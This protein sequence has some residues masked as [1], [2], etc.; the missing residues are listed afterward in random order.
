VSSVVT[1][2][3]LLAWPRPYFEPGG[4]D[5]HLFYK[6]HGD[7]SKPPPVSRAKYRTAGIPPGIQTMQL[8]RDRDGDAFR[9]GLDDPFAARLREEHPELVARIESAPHAIVFRG[10]LEDPE[11][12][13]YFRDIIG[14][15]TAFLDGGAVA[16]LDPFRLDWWTREE[17][18]ERVFDP[19]SPNVLEHV[20]IL[21]GED[22]QTA[23]AYWMHTRGMIKFGRPDLSIRGLT[24]EQL[25]GGEEVCTRFIGGQAFGALVPEGKEVNVEALPGNWVCRHGGSMDDPDFNN[26]H[27]DIRME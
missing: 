6:L 14:V 11:N 18:R 25:P 7:F 24:E 1:P 5:A 15:I 8:D 26:V 13:D 17:W 16:L 2:V 21:L 22:E 27:I 20:Q 23:G 19:A 10:T 3:P 4:G 9:F 12:L